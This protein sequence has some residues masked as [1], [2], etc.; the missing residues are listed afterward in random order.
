MNC[1][2][3]LAALCCSF[4][5]ACADD[6]MT[7]KPAPEPVTRDDTGYFCGMIVEDHAGPKS[8]IFVAGEPDPLWFTTARDG[9]AFQRLPEETR[10]I[11][12]FY[13]SAVD[14]GGWD[15]PEHDLASMIDA[16][17]AWFVIGSDRKGSMGAPEVIP[18]SEE[19]AALAFAEQFGGEVRRL[20]EI[21][22]D[23]ILGASQSGSDPHAGHR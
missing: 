16:E 22:G 15:H 19:P 10:P 3:L 12:A 13:V 21:P 2:H 1:K 17:R 9:V 5:F 7:V 14:L 11:L 4:L 6:S 20:A 23:Y 8:Q 18:F